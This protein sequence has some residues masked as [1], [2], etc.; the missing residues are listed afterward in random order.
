M[1]TTG[2]VFSTKDIRYVS[3]GGSFAAP[4]FQ[5]KDKLVLPSALTVPKAVSWF[6]QQLEAILNRIPP[7]RLGYRIAISN[8]THKMI[9]TTF[10]AQAI[11][12]LLADRRNIEI[13][14]FAAT[15]IVPSKF[16]QPHNVELDSYVDELLGSHPPYWDKSTKQAALISLLL[17][18][19]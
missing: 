6:E 16:G 15:S 13:A 4:L 12:N 9:Q 3:L 14:S 18:K 17:L 7:D 5:H 2:F 19:E 11:L 10:F 8:V 1:I